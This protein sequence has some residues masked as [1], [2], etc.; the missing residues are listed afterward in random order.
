MQVI[1]QQRGPASAGDIQLVECT[2]RGGFLG[3]F[4][5]HHD[6]HGNAVSFINEMREGDDPAVLNADCYDAPEGVAC[7]EQLEDKAGVGVA[8]MSGAG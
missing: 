1:R 2:V 3:R 6:G 5:A 8:H 7:K 4:N